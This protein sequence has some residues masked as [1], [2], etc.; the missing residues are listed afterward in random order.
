MSSSLSPLSSTSD[1]PPSFDERQIDLASGVSMKVTSCVPPSY[2]WS[3]NNAKPVLVFLHGSFHGGWCWTEHFFAF[4]ASQQGYPVVAPCWRG[5][6]GTYAGDGVKKVKIQEHVAD[7]QSLLDQLPAILSV[8]G[9]NSQ[10]KGQPRN[11]N[12]LVIRPIL[13][14]HSFGSLAVM[15]LLELHPERMQQLR[16]IVMMCPVPPSGNGIIIGRFLRRF[17][18]TAS[19]KI[20]AGFAMKKVLT[21]AALCRDLF[22]GGNKNNNNDDDPEPNGVSDSDIARYQQYFAR[23]SEATIDLL[24]LSKQ[25]PSAA[26]VENGKAPFY[27]TLPPCLVMGAT[28]DFIVDAEGVEETAR[29][30]NVEKPIFV[31]SPHDVMLTNQWRN[32]ATALNEWLDQLIPTS[33]M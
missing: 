32:A 8:D 30:F 3:E 1:A 14:A 18:F 23:D 28:K 31:D 21:N 22:F 19:Y 6:G 13:I 2:S 9:D 29:Y 4:F 15:K 5:T 27:Q 10:N 26:T 20:T 33:T 17:Q 16:G 7:L 11:K 24:D 25:L 12:P